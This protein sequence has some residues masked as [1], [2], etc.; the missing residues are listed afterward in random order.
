MTI[1]MIKQGTH[2]F[3]RPIKSASSLI[4][5]NDTA[6]NAFNSIHGLILLSE[7][8]VVVVTDIAPDMDI[9]GESVVCCGL[10]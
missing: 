9:E 4:T 1:I 5:E 2:L 8:E 6:V 10:V 7:G 3:F